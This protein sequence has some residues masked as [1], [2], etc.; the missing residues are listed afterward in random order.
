[1]SRWEFSASQTAF[2]DLASQLTFEDSLEL[3]I[4]T[5]IFK[6]KRKAQVYFDYSTNKSLRKKTLNRLGDTTPLIPLKSSTGGQVVGGGSIAKKIAE[7]S[8]DF[9]FYQAIDDPS[10]QIYCNVPSSFIMSISSSLLS[11]VET[12]EFLSFLERRYAIFDKIKCIS[13]YVLF[14][15]PDTF[16]QTSIS[17]WRRRKLWLT[18]K[19]M[20]R[21]S[22]FGLNWGNYLGPDLLKLL[23][24]KDKFKEEYLAF[25]IDDNFGEPPPVF[26]YENGLF[27]TLSAR[28]EICMPNG[29]IL[30]GVTSRIEWL[31]DRFQDAGIEII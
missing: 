16:R 29:N 1:M 28:P 18:Q 20:S 21:S 7:T 26:S 12:G 14:E 31:C 3:W 11:R 27:F 2:F 30:D 5:G 10:F 22:I 13:G 9:D 6:E 4:D 25:C 24:G 19:W 15:Y 17:L 23:G 8:Y